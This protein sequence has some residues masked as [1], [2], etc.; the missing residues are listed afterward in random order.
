MWIFWS[1]LDSEVSELKGSRY[2]NSK[3]KL[4]LN[5]K[6]YVREIECLGMV[7]VFEVSKK[8]AALPNQGYSLF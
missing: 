6:P 2:A 1:V 8:A 3:R 4:L 7:F 5:I